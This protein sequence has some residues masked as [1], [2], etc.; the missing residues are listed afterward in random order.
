MDL[1]LV[2]AVSF[3]AVW[4]VAYYVKKLKNIDVDTVTKLILQGIIMYGI[5]LIPASLGNIW[6]DNLKIVIGAVLGTT[7]VYQGPKGIV[8]SLVANNV[9][10]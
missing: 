7:A 3:G 10:K 5:L 4:V 9:K 1:A 8:K 2:T 6:L